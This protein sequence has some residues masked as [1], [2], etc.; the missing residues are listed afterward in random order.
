MDHDPLWSL[1]RFRRTETLPWN[2]P[3][4]IGDLERGIKDADQR[5]RVLGVGLAALV[6]LGFGDFSSEVARNAPRWLFFAYM[7]L[8]FSA[9]FLLARSWIEGHTSRRWIELADDFCKKAEKLD[10]LSGDA[11]VKKARCSYVVAGTLIRVAIWPMVIAALCYMTAVAWW[12][13]SG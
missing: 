4:T 10:S 2:E 11:N 12:A 9:G 13:A 8:A 5:V 7:T 1:V 6:A 3:T